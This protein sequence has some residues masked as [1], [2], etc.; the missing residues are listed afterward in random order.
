MA[1]G[2]TLNQ[3]SKQLKKQIFS[4]HNKIPNPKFK[5]SQKEKKETPFTA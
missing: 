3:V 1:K 4:S 5:A 2:F